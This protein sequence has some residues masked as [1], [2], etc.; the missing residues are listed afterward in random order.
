MSIKWVGLQKD[1]KMWNN[2]IEGSS[3]RKG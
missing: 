2:I 1:R 3:S